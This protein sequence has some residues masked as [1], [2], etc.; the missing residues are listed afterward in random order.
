MA[1]I[2]R[3]GDFLTSGHFYC[4]GSVKNIGRAG[5]LLINNFDTRGM[6]TLESQQEGEQLKSEI[7]VKLDLSVVRYS[8]VWEDCEILCRGLDIQPSDVVLSITR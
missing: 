6:E 4:S 3:K 1:E 7:A 8:R 5:L 2:V